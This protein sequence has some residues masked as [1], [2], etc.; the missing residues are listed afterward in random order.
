V[1]SVLIGSLLI[2]APAEAAQSRPPLAAQ[3]ERLAQQLDSPRL[4]ERDAAER[5]L[6]EL[7]APILPLLPAID[8]RTS[9]EVATRLARLQQT[10]L[11]AQAVA[12]AD[13]TLVTLK[14]KDLPLSGV[15]ATI[16]KQ[17]GNAIVD[18]RAAFGEEPRESRVSVEFDKTPFW[19]AID[20]VL[21]QGELTLYGFTGRRGASF[22]GRPPG[23]AP[24]AAH[25]CYAGMF[26]F[27]PLKFVALR[28]LRN[29]T[30]ESLK[31]TMEV[32]WEPRL[33]PFAIM[34]PLSEV[35]ATDSRGEPIAVSGAESEPEALVRE[36]IS[37]I[38]LEIPLALPK[39]EVKVIGL[40]RGKILVLMPGPLEDFRF[41]ELPLAVKGGRPGRV[42]QRKAGAL[43]AL[44][45]V[46]K[47]NE[48]WEVAL[49]IKFEGPSAALE[50]HRSW[51]LE[52]Q[53]FFEQAD[54]AR[55]EPAGIEQTLQNKEEMGVHY[56]FDLKDGPKNLTFVY[57]TPII[58]LELPVAYE[59]RDLRLP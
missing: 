50:S 59:F 36:G 35:S 49:R 43:V 1:I 53:A 52:N 56:F 54:G 30:L 44:D 32:A 19:R 17:T 37:A 33:Q 31:F 5:Q 48:A 57:R 4:N 25:A 13:A 3:V 55:I 16:A 28:D 26:R 45:H 58:V 42:E 29:P 7:G 22:V 46:R 23:A 9:G 6:L 18:H 12:A 40:L 41:S 21:D 39:R 14:G 15:L 34:Q 47:N 24:R 11:R 10:L 38:E 8:Q 27:E 51:I 20:A 2:L